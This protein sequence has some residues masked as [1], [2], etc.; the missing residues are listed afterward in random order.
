[1]R[2]LS[3][4]TDKFWYFGT[5]AMRQ[6]Y[7]IYKLQK[8]GNDMTAAIAIMD[9]KEKSVQSYVA[10]NDE[11]ESKPLSITA[12]VLIIVSSI[13]LIAMIFYCIKYIREK[14]N[15]R[16]F[17]NEDQSYIGSINNKK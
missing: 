6:F 17:D 14:K 16:H 12:I 15:E 4:P 2:G 3:E 7:I 10:P 13:I 8:S 9:S 1:V 5:W 11:E